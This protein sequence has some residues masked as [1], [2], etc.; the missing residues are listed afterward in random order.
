MKTTNTSKRIQVGSRVSIRV[1]RDVLTVTEIA[2]DV[3]RYDNGTVMPVW[4]LEAGQK[5]GDYIV[6]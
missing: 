3:V 5:T 6:V 4:V 2:G 1:L